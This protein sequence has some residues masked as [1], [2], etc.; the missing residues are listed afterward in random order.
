[1]TIHRP[2]SSARRLGLGYRPWKR[3]L[4]ILFT[5]HRNATAAVLLTACAAAVYCSM[6]H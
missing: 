5:R 3:N 1:M 2:K 6:L 4:H